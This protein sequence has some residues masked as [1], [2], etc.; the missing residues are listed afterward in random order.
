MRDDT[1]MQ[2][3]SGKS[4]LHDELMDGIAKR[5][6]LIRADAAIRRVQCVVRLFVARKRAQ[7]ARI[8]NEILTYGSKLCCDRI[9]D[10][11]VMSI[12]LGI[13]NELMEKKSNNVVISQT[14]VDICTKLLL[15][16]VDDFVSIIVK[17]TINDCVKRYMEAR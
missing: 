3:N 10:E 5:V 9:L 1:T 12:I 15:E 8:R 13:V 16:V 4:D 2:I 11:S 7:K 14:V 17:E 6:M